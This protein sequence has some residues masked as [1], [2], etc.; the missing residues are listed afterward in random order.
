MGKTTV[1]YDAHTTV[2]LQSVAGRL[3]FSQFP[4]VLPHSVGPF[5]SFQHA[6]RVNLLTMTN[7]S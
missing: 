5:I 6:A 1:Q 3:L 2:E 4:V 7:A